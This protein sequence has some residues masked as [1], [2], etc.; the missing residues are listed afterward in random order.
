[1]KNLLKSISLVLTL[2]FAVVGT[3]T[4][5]FADD[6]QDLQ[7]ISA[8]LNSV[9][10]MQGKFVQVSPDAAVTQG[11]FYM[12]RPG[13]I[14]FEY[15]DPN[16]SVVIADGFWVTV[17]DKNKGGSQQYPLSATPLYIL[18]K[19]NVDLASE[20]AVQRIERLK[21]QLRVTAIDPN[22]RNNGHITMVFANSPL[23]L[24]QWVISDPQGLKTTVA[25]RDMKANVKVDAAKFSIP[26]A[27]RQTGGN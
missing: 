17:M 6:Y 20:G 15:N 10:T 4:A 23:E 9:K 18:L 26:T 7:R 13:K 24:R 14:R 1:M 2:A 12:K 5:A 27:Q 21:G 3:N 19:N 22:N 25:L 8:Y 16:P 11:D